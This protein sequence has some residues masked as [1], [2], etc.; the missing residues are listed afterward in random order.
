MVHPAYQGHG[1]ARTM[2]HQYIDQAQPAFLTTYTRNPSILR[3]LRH[4]SDDIY[5]LV[6]DLMLRNMAA[7]MDHASQRDVIYHLDRYGEEGLFRG[8]DPADG[9]LDEGEVS[10]KQQYAELASVRHAL[11]VAARVRRES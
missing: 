11:V 10:L 1:I 4:V 5:P 3:M 2:L 9:S 6:D 7:M 8:T